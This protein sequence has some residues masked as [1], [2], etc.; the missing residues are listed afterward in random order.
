MLAPV[1][2][3]IVLFKGAVREVAEIEL[4]VVHRSKQ[5]LKR[6]PYAGDDWLAH[7]GYR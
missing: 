4:V 7:E 6:L 5:R 2:R 1:E 3:R